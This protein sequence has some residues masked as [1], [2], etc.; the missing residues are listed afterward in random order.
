MFRAVVVSACV[1]AGCGS[2]SDGATPEVYSA[3]TDEVAQE[4]T[5]PRGPV[6]LPS[7]PPPGAPEPGFRVCDV[8]SS[9]V[10]PAEVEG[11]HTTHGLEYPDLHLIS[12]FPWRE[13][14]GDRWS[15]D[16]NVEQV[17]VDDEVAGG[18]LSFDMTNRADGEPLPPAS[19]A[20]PAL[21]PQGYVNVSGWVSW[22]QGGWWLRVEGPIE[23]EEDFRVSVELAM[24]I[25]DRI[26]EGSVAPVPD[27]VVHDNYL[28][29]PAEE[30]VTRAAGDPFDLDDMVMLS[31]TFGVETDAGHKWELVLFLGGPEPYAEAKGSVYTDCVDTTEEDVGL[32][33]FG[34]DGG[35]N[36]S[37]QPDVART[38]AYEF[39]GM[40]SDAGVSG[41]SCTLSRNFGVEREPDDDV[42][43]PQGYLLL[44]DYYTQ[45]PIEGD[46]ES[47]YDM[48]IT[49]S[50]RPDTLREIGADSAEVTVTEVSI[51]A[52]DGTPLKVPSEQ[53]AAL[54]GTFSY[55]II[56]EFIAAPPG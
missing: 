29:Q 45:D 50:L 21:G 32:V 39:G 36:V 28:A 9:Y 15:S 3:P 12:G 24:L 17:G 34:L 26:A 6:P 8:M 46:R 30:P 48:T 27:N 7:V 10:T 33:S 23:T 4:V 41:E 51:G 53:L 56:E 37:D 16:C 13:S 31:V 14:F 40:P 49:P 38:I 55:R 43:G 25:H 2:E 35:T 20:V 5:V 47:F 22:E 1:L 11:I 44:P 42:L 19:H 54:G 18:R 52:P